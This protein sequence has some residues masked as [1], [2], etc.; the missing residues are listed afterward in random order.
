MNSPQ[1]WLND[2]YLEQLV[3]RSSQEPDYN[4]G[5]CS[6][7]LLRVSALLPR[8]LAVVSHMTGVMT[9]TRDHPFTCIL[10]NSMNGL[11]ERHICSVIWLRI[12]QRFPVTP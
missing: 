4:C 11:F 5:F 3:L 8:T 2:M 6:G 1:L 12:F 7:H 9:F 10:H